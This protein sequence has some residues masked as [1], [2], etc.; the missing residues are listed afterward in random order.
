ML[1]IALLVALSNALNIIETRRNILRRAPECD[2][3]KY[4]NSFGFRISAKTGAGADSL[5][6]AVAK[7]FNRMVE[8]DILDADAARDF[9]IEFLTTFKSE[10]QYLGNDYENAISRST[11]GGELSLLSL[12]HFLNIKITVLSCGWKV[13]RIYS[14]DIHTD[15]R[16][17]YLFNS[18]SGEHYD[19]MAPLIADDASLIDLG[20]QYD[21]TN[22][23]LID[24]HGDSAHVD[25]AGNFDAG[26]YNLDVVKQQ[27]GYHQETI[28]TFWGSQPSPSHATLLHPMPLDSIQPFLPQTPMPVQYVAHQPVS[29]AFRPAMPASPPPP[30]PFIDGQHF[31]KPPTDFAVRPPSFQ[32]DTPSFAMVPFNAQQESHSSAPQSFSS[33]AVD[34]MVVFKPEQPK[35][36]VTSQNPFASSQRSVV[37]TAVKSEPAKPLPIKVPA[38]VKPAPAAIPHFAIAPVKV[39]HKPAFKRQSRYGVGTDLPAF[40]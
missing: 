28:D 25:Y 34:Q 36:P 21:P 17:I 18:G 27:Q 37:Y 30:P 35:L 29:D 13:P 2:A 11:P 33:A 10:Y 20:N 14:P 8:D 5:F 38:S 12:S 26:H 32:L 40:D 19:I 16:S 7:D 31:G 24:L 6:E 4:L 39:T 1:P 22:P 23:S 3:T 15:D 9:S